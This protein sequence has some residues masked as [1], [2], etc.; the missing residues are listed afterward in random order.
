VRQSTAPAAASE[1]KKYNIVV[2]LHVFLILE[3]VIEQYVMLSFCWHFFFSFTKAHERV[4]FSYETY[5][6]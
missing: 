5:F 6:E 1:S 4:L 3:S 2:Q